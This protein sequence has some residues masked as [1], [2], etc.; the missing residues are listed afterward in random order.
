MEIAN[1]SAPKA[2]ATQAVNFN[3]ICCFRCVSSS[4][5]IASPNSFKRAA[6][7]LINPACSAWFF[8]T[9]SSRSE[10]PPWAFFWSA[11]PLRI[12]ASFF[13]RSKTS[14]TLVVVSMRACRAIWR[15]MWNIKK[16][17][18]ATLT[19]NVA[20]EDR[21]LFVSFGHELDDAT[22]NESQSLRGEKVNTGG[23]GPSL[24]LPGR[25][26]EPAG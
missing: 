20:H 23:A 16:E 3:L 22:T 6:N 11:I 19:P 13:R 15:G 7:S 21:V 26:G 8:S 9:T 2:Q 25:T 12:E 18:R 1:P 14:Q 24:H 17:L 10:S 5:C 4:D